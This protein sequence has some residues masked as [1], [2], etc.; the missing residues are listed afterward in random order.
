M[1]RRTLVGECDES[2]PAVRWSEDHAQPRLADALDK[3][4]GALL[5]GP[6]QR[7]HHQAANRVCETVAEGLRGTTSKLVGDRAAEPIG[8]PR[9]TFEPS[10]KPDTTP[11]TSRSLTVRVSEPAMERQRCQISLCLA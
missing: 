5:L 10:F 8:K 7:L 11:V 3:A 9:R 2:E 1:S 4:E 6:S